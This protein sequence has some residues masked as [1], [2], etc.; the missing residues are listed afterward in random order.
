MKLTK[1]MKIIINFSFVFAFTLLMSCTDEITNINNSTD[2]RVIGSIHGVVTDANT[3]ARINGIEVT[4]VVDGNIY[5][6]LTDSL[7]YYSITNL[8]PGNYEISCSGSPDYAIGRTTVS[9]PT[10]QQ[11]GIT[12]SPTSENFY[13]SEKMDI[14]LYMLNAGVS[15]TVWAQ[16]NEENTNLANG[17]TMVA[18][19][20]NYDISP[21]K[22]YTTTNSDGS[23]I[24]TN[25]P[26][27]NDVEL[28]TMPFNDGTSNYDVSSN[29]VTLLPNIT[30]QSKSIILYI[31]QATSF[32]VQNNFMNNN[33]N[34]Y[35]D[36]ILTFSKPMDPSSFHIALSSPTFGNVEFESTWN[37]DGVTLTINPYVTLQVNETYSLVLTGR[38]KDNNNFSD[39]FTFG[40]TQG[41]Q[42]VKTNLERID[43]VFNDFGIYNNIEITFTENVDLNNQDGYVYLIDENSLIGPTTNSLTSDSKT[44]IINPIDN[45]LFDHN[46]T[47]SYKVYSTFEQDFVTGLISFQT[48]R[49]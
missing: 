6:T 28:L 44:L 1:K 37:S 45:L 7:G 30:T 36:L 27:T 33:F 12:D 20:S 26:A 32:I 11:I 13:H 19:F 29:N 49:N 23:F 46:Y 17:V 43:G 34:L 14:N 21:D 25:L 8:S 48:Q 47:L 42:F 18:D 24:F 9:I 5:A 15:G 35:D 3:N 41:I 31:S 22:Y 16:Y 39:S 38:S 40:T 10:L 2:G 4:T